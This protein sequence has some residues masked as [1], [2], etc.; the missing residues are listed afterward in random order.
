MYTLWSSPL[1]LRSVCTWDHVLEKLQSGADL[2]TPGLTWWDPEIRAG[3]I[4]AITLEDRVPVAV[5]VAAFDVGYLAESKGGKGKAI[6]LVH[7]HHDELWGLGNRADP[8][9]PPPNDP[10]IEALEVSTQ[11]LSLDESERPA[12]IQEV[13]ELQHIQEP[14]TSGLSID[15]V[16]N[17]RN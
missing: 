6:Y 11:K 4:T 1:F 2:M 3:D 8:P 16:S 9:S 10:T 12:V 14:S 5:G 15:D 13:N 7:C 17:H